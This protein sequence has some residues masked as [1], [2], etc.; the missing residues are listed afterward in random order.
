[1]FLAA[2]ALASALAAASWYHYADVEIRVL[3]ARE[4]VRIFMSMRGEAVTGDAGHALDCLEYTL[5]YYPAGTK[6]VDPSPLNEIVEASRRVAVED[7]V[8]AL[9]LKTGRD[10]GADPDVWIKN[11]GVLVKGPPKAV[12][13]GPK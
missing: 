3:M 13:P 10:L 2:L 12:I 1:M 8:S 4:Q 5:A 9:R 11:R 7:I 6:Q